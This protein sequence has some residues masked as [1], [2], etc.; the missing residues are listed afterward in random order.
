MSKNTKTFFT[1]ISADMATLLGSITH[2]EYLSDSS[3]PVG[4][5][6][7]TSSLGHGFSGSKVGGLLSYAQKQG[8]VILNGDGSEDNDYTVEI[9]AR[10]YQLLKLMAAEIKEGAQV[11]QTA[12]AKATAWANDAADALVAEAETNAKR[13]AEAKAE[14]EKVEAEKQAAFD[15]EEQAAI[16][17][18]DKIEADRLEA[19]AKKVQDE[20]IKAELAKLDEKPVL[21]VVAKPKTASTRVT[22]TS[23]L[24]ANAQ[25]KMKISGDL[26]GT[27]TM[28][29]TGV[30]GC[31]FWV[32]KMNPG[33]TH[34]EGD[35]MWSVSSITSMTQ[36][37]KMV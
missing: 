12:N 9:T 36:A 7:W 10:G 29:V 33:E 13:E 18:H 20:A 23:E 19:E 25:P 14:A 8:W 3:K 30:K 6:V 34:F 2:N 37:W 17:A 24:R 35:R 15:A 22:F 4:C 21:D 32:G 5:P 31:N 28:E 11:R 27:V 16:A 26:D 1:S